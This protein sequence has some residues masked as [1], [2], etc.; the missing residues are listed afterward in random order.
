MKTRPYKFISERISVQPITNSELEKAQDHYE[1][2]KN[3]FGI[4][5]ADLTEHLKDFPMGVVVRMMEEAKRQG[6]TDDIKVMCRYPSGVF[7]YS[8][9]EAGHI[10]WS[11]IIN[12]H[13][14]DEFFERYPDYKKYN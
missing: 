3:P 4:V 13:I 12:N 2:A 9:T 8:D 7:V 14:F 5:K 1:R 11:K 6:N 10:F